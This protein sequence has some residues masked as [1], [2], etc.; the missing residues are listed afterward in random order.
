MWGFAEIYD[1]L[2]EAYGPQGWWPLIEDGPDGLRCR[3]TPDNAVKELNRRERFEIC[4][5]AILT[6]NTNWSNAERALVSLFQAGILEPEALAGMAPEQIADHIRS[7]GYYNQKA[8]KLKAFSQFYLTNPPPDRKLFLAQWGLGPETVDDML[9]YA[10]NQPVFV[11]DIYTTRLFSRL[12][13][14][15]AAVTYPDLQDLVMNRL[16]KDTLLYKEYHALIVRHAKEHCKKKP[17]CGGCPLESGCMQARSA[18]K[19]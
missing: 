6:Q 15:D 1:R 16:K 12:G 19:A 3:Y 9:L 4:A 13:L 8:R 18:G 17:D 10:Y 14:C 11:I 2:Y 5:G 7:S